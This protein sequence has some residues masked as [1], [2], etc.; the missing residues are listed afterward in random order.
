M[1]ALTWDAATRL[2]KE[3]ITGRIFTASTEPVDIADGDLW[4]DSSSTPVL[5]AKVAGVIYEVVGA[6]GGGGGGSDG[7]LFVDDVVIEAA[8]IADLLGD[9]FFTEAIVF[10]YNTV[11]DGTATVTLF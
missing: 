9:D 1:K 3:V 6:G 8:L 4:I 10:Q 5:K 7:G 2:F 11:D